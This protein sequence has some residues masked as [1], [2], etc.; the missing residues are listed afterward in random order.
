MVGIRGEGAELE[1]RALLTRHWSATFAANLQ[2]TTVRGPDPSFIVVPPSAVGVAPQDGYGGSYAVF[3]VSTLRP[4]DYTDTLIPRYVASPYL[5][6][7]GDRHGWGQLGATAGFSAIGATAGILPGAVRL[8][9]Y[10]T[11]NGSGFW[12]SGPWRVTVNVD[13]LANTLAF[14]PVADVYAEVAALPIQ[15]RTW[16][17]RLRRAF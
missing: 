15:G 3:A 16:R 7:T 13:N 4:G 5:T 2:R 8:P 9:A 12:Q 6:W 10:V 1:L 17:A 14:T 11:A